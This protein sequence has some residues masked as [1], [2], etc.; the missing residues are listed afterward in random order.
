MI[1]VILTST[2]SSR[3]PF[4]N[5]AYGPSKAA[6]GW[7]T[8]QIND[9]EQRINAFGLVPGW[10][11]TDMGDSGAKAFGVDEATKSA[12]MISTDVSCD[13]MMKVLG[14]TTKQDHGGKL[15]WYDGRETLW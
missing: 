14:R 1:A 10:V 6:A 13:G 15:I 7:L 3:L 9:E 2:F 4:P 5:A 11:H 8:I 12:L